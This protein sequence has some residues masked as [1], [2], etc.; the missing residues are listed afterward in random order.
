M[1]A[2]KNKEQFHNGQRARINFRQRGKPH[3]KGEENEEKEF[4]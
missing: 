4:P 1:Q 3:D 2:S